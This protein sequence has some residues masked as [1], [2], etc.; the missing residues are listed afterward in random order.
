MPQFTYTQPTAFAGMLADGGRLDVVSAV[1]PLLPQ[2]S[3]ITI[4]GVATAGAHTIRVSAPEGDIDVTWTA[5]GGE[6]VAATVAAI[7]AAFDAESDLS[8]IVV[9][10]DASPDITLTFIH[11]GEDYTVTLISNPGSNMSLATTQAAGG[12][13][14][15][16]GYGVMYFAN[17]DGGTVKL[18]DASV[19]GRFAG[20]AVRS[21]A[22]VMVNSTEASFTAVTAFEPGAEVSI[23]RSGRCWVYATQAVEVG[24][25]AYCKYQNGTTAAPV[26]SWS[27]SP[28]DSIS[29]T[30]ARFLTTT[31]GPGLALLE[32]NP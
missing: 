3:T 28:T 17:T 20:V 30:G 11:E 14:I 18:P 24:D 31:T 22:N 16:L 13:D 26:G 2:I 6:S 12:T 23:L 4:G 1:N 32:L 7:V 10:T 19:P 9:A 8:N 5:T 15:P 21:D 25:V 27:D 29:G